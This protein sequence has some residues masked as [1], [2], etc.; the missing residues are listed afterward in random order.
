MLNFWPDPARRHMKS[1]TC[2]RNHLGCAYWYPSQEFLVCLGLSILLVDEEDHYR[3]DRM[4]LCQ[5]LGF[6]YS[7]GTVGKGVLGC[8][9][10]HCQHGR[11]RWHGYDVKV[12]PLEWTGSRDQAF[13]NKCQISCNTQWFCSWQGDWCRPANDFSTDSSSCCCQWPT[14]V[15]L[16]HHKS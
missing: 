9:A 12:S 3:R 10:W 4:E 6:R 7:A 15:P 16:Q 13:K 2:R 14:L 5:G 1:G 11:Q 8:Y